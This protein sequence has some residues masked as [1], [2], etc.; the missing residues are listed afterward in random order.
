MS[1]DRPTRR[2]V[3]AGAGAAAAAGAILGPSALAARAAK[4]PRRTLGRTGKK[5]PIL[6]FGAAMNLDPVFDRKIAEAVRNGV[7]Y[8]DAAR[9]YGGGS[10]ESAVGAYLKRA[11]NRKKV[12]ITSKSESHDP[13]GYRRGVQKSLSELGTDYIDL[14]F[15]HALRDAGKLSKEMA[16][17]AERLKKEG[18]IRFFGFSCHHGNVAELL[19]A[20]ARRP[21]VDAVMFRYN[22]REYGDAKLNKAI[23][24]AAKANV[25]LIAMKTQ[26]SAVSFADEW[27]KFQRTGKWNRHQA[28][29]KAVWADDRI[30]AAVSH[31]DSL[32]KVKE[33]VAAATDKSGLSALEQGELERYA[34]ETRRFA[35]SGCDHLCGAH[36][37]EPIPIADVMRH[38]MYHDAYGERQEARALFRAL[39]PEAR[40]IDSVDFRAAAAACPHGFDLAAHMRRAARVLG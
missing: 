37:E 20:A 21:W 3:I 8:I 22:F 16:R 14:Y 11:K 31:M 28:V 6:L 9:S 19:E 17:T 1:K 39:P 24:A 23:D 25:G 18:K 12:W 5:V 34:A 27:K 33:N 4:V 2:D 38:L 40:R 35:C 36:I 7:D 30:T 15:M 10:C 32:G 13:A 26:S 29:L